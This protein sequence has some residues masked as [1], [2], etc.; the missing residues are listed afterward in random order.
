[1]HLDYSVRIPH[2]NERLLFR[3]TLAVFLE[4]VS[5]RLGSTHIADFLSEPEI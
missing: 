3:E 1:M 2:E 4:F 5:V